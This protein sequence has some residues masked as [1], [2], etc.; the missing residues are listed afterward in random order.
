MHAHVA[1]RSAKIILL[2][3]ETAPVG[4]SP[5]PDILTF[6]KIHISQSAVFDHISQYGA[7]P[8]AVVL[9]RHKDSSR[10]LG[11]RVDFLRIRQRHADRFFT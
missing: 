2:D 4:N 5:A 8:H 3:V 10:A 1:E 9:N 6:A 7:G 11:R